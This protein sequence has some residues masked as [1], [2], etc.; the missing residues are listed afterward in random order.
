LLT[1]SSL[2][3]AGEHHRSA[4]RVGAC[5]PGAIVIRGVSVTAAEGALPG[6]DLLAARQI[7]CRCQF[8]NSRSRAF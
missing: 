1:E 8:A 5:W 4:H 3:P 2:R 7:R 6:A